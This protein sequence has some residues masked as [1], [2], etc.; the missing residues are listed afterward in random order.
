MNADLREEAARCRAL[1]C[2]VVA[3]LLLDSTR[4]DSDGDAARAWLCDPDRLALELAGIDPEPAAEALARGDRGH[5]TL[6]HPRALNRRLGQ[7]SL[8]AKL[9]LEP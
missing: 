6:Y 2:A 1:W 4:P 5:L 7:K 9:S 8:A 3:R